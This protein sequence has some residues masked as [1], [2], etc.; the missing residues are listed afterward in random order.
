MSQSKTQG[1]GELQEKDYRGLLALGFTAGFFA[2]CTAAL[3]AG[4]MP[5]LQLTAAFLGSLEGSII[6]F[7]FGQRGKGQ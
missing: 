1:I 2:T 5:A 4:G 7:Y 3:I 6:G